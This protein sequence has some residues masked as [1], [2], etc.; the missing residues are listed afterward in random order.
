MAYRKI[1][2]YLLKYNYSIICLIVLIAVYLILKVNLAFLHHEVIWD[3]AVYIGIGKYIYSLGE[4]G[5][6]ESIRPPGLPLLLGALWKMDLPIVFFSELMMILFGAVNIG[7]IYVITKQ[8]SNKETALLASLLFVIS[9][10]FFYQ[11]SLILTHVPA[12]SFTL[13][14]VYLVLKKRY[15]YTGIFIGGAF[16]S[17]YPQGILLAA[18]CGYILI[19]KENKKNKELRYKHLKE[20]VRRISIVLTG[21]LIIIL[22]LLILNYIKYEGEVLFPFIDAA[23]HQGN[24]VYKI[25]NPTYNLFFYLSELVKQ[26]PLLIFGLIGIYLFL[27]DRKKYSYS[28]RMIVVM[29]LV[30]PFLYYTTIINKQLRFSIEFLPYLSMLAA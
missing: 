24:L 16:L 13:F 27:S 4:I 18:I 26:N 20:A 23:K 15:F 14:A 19:K 17:R 2:N 30:F 12:I 7:L 9:P 5:I 28:E 11:S 21:F 3:E 6:W 29:A 22:P 10:I 8:F 25:S 1:K